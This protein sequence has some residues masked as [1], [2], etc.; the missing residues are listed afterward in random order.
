[1]SAENV[2]IVRRLYERTLRDGSALAEFLDDEVEWELGEFRMPDWAETVHGPAA[3]LEFFHR[4]TAPFDE[5]GWE[6][7]EVIDAGDDV[8]AHLRQWGRGKSSGATVDTLFWQVWT[9]RGGK[10]IRGRHYTERKSALRAA[11]LSE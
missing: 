10:A 6:V 5:W 2:E 11:G 3:V 7:I 1:M 8:V 9:L 4:W